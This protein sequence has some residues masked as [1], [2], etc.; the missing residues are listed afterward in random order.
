MAAL[1]PHFYLLQELFSK[2]R[3]YLAIGCKPGLLPNRAHQ[4]EAEGESVIFAIIFL[5]KP[6]GLD[7]YELP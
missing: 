4:V 7:C 6:D 3:M 1:P 2:I 5:E